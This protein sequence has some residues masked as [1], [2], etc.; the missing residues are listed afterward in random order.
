K[1]LRVVVD[2]NRL[3]DEA[4]DVLNH[5]LAVLYDDATDIPSLIKAIRW[6]ELY[7]DL[8][9]ATDRGEDVANT[10]E[11]IVLKHA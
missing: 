5:A 3:E 9:V 8:E 11:G 1:M 10:L 7:T 6:G 4:D 2:I